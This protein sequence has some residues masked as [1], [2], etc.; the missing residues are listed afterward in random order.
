MVNNLICETLNPE[1]PIAKIYNMLN[2]YTREEQEELIKE[3]NKITLNNNK[4]SSKQMKILKKH[5]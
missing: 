1:N 3:C 5:V 4:F 2:T